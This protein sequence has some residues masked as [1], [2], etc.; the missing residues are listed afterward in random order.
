MYVPGRGSVLRG[1]GLVL[2]GRD[3]VLPGRG[4]VLP[5]RGLVLR[6]RGSVLRGRG[7]VL[8]GQGSGLRVWDLV[9]LV[10][11]GFAAGFRAVTWLSGR[12]RLA[13]LGRGHLLWGQPPNGVGEGRRL[14]LWA[15]KGT[16]FGTLPHPP[17]ALHVRA[18]GSHHL[19]R[20]VK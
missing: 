11:K 19:L 3:S 20:Q 18:L 9:R 6:G 14:A 7:S 5:G 12:R 16:E 13:N 10:P 1:R 4:L 17:W 15:L 8:R 2:R